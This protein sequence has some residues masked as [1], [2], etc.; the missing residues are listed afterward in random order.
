MRRDTRLTG[1][2]LVVLATLASSILIGCGGDNSATGST[3][4]SAAAN[5][6]SA[7]RAP[8]VSANARPTAITPSIQ[9]AKALALPNASAPNASAPLAANPGTASGVA[10]NAATDL[11]TQNMQASLAADSRQVAPV[12]QYAPGDSSD[13]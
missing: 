7:Q 9:N 4:S 8:D 1:V 13:N 3:S 2:V 10:T 11:I 12:M 5:D 6:D